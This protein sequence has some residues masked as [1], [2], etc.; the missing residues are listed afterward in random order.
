[1]HSGRPP[2]RQRWI[3]GVGSVAGLVLAAGIAWRIGHDAMSENAIAPAAA[4]SVVPVQPIDGTTRAKREQPAISE[5][6]APNAQLA[7]AP[8][9]PGAS[10][11]AAGRADVTREER[12]ARV[13]AKLATPAPKPAAAPP[14]PAAEPFPAEVRQRA[15]TAD[16][17]LEKSDAF[18]A[19]AAPEKKAAS[20][21]ASAGAIAP[22]TGLERHQST[23]S[24]S[25]TPPSGSVEL[26]RDMQLA[27]LAWLAHIRA[28]ERDGRR[29]QASES[30]RLF[31]RVHPDRR[32]PPD[33]QALLD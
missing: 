6:A 26:Q 14:P 20:G 18:D 28:L 33:L 29:Q 21:A 31:I 8:S 9:K 10:S 22:A 17:D 13:A 5:S 19:A 7:P 12:K 16:K 27:P 23:K 30:L 3:V 2:R 15:A 32:V 1:V 11:G 4:P 25:S 24:M